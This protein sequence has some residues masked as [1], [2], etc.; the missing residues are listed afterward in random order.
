MIL[1]KKKFY[2]NIYFIFSFLFIAQSLF[3]SFMGISIN[4]NTS[5]SMA[6][7]LIINFIFTLLFY[8]FV[9][10]ND[11]LEK[12]L[13]IFAR[14]GMIFSLVIVFVSIDQIFSGRLGWDIS[15][16]IFGQYVRYNANTIA[17]I[18]G[19]SYLIYLYKYNK[20][21][22]NCDLF[23]LVWFSLIVLLTGSRKGL[24]LVVFG[25]ILLLFMLNPKSRIKNIFFA[26]LAAITFYL[27]VMKMP[28]FY[29]IIGYRMEALISMFSGEEI[30]EGS[31]KTRNLFVELGWEYFKL[32]PWTGY[33]LD[34][35]RHFPGSYGTY[36][37]NNY[38]EILISGGI[39]SLIFYYFIRLIILVRLFLNQ[40]KDFIN[41]LLF[42]ILLILLI[43]DY[44]FVSYFDR[45]YILL[46]VF[47]LCGY[48]QIK[49]KRSS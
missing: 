33:G 9:L 15:L 31:A 5:L 47:V 17:L 1:T 24:F 20:L 8:N 30:E 25:T 16:T 34:T 11:Y 40:N 42:V 7:T 10:I 19:I 23:F 43:L 37:H 14:V 4:Q 45:I 39:P 13:I 29:N 22:N 26:S 49:Y 3:V 27:V 38:I 28:V 21:K 2:F 12:S 32:R 44:G 18:S 46:F 6:T 41:K 36:S 35:F 48:G